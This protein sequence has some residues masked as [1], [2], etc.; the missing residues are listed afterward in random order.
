[1]ARIR[2]GF[3]VIP[4]GIAA[5]GIAAVA[6]RYLREIRAARQELER[7][8]SR[9][10]QTEFGPIEY[11]CVGSGYPVL[12][13]HGAMGGFDQG[14]MTA[15]WMAEHGFQVI[16]VSRFGYLRTPMPENANGDMQADANAC[17]LDALGI[18]K[19]AVFGA[20][21]G[22]PSAVRFAARYPGR[23]TALVLLSPA[24]P[25]EVT[26]APPK[27]ALALARNDF[28]Y[29]SM[30]TYL[31]PLMQ[32]AIGVPQGFKPTAEDAAEITRVLAKTLPSSGRGDL[33]YF[34]DPWA[35]EFHEQISESSPYPLGKIETPILVLNAQDDPFSIPAN[36]RRY[37]ERF[38]NARLHVVPDGGHFL[39]GHGAEVHAAITQFLNGVA[40][41]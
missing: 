29:W 33:Y 11:A 31:R 36:V 24:A 30:V 13:L 21:G 25:G 6:A 8:G 37:T 3:G 10:L 38:P 28:I 19:A 16:A 27:A 14:L 7:L 22:A 12:V 39:L 26:V 17:L 4:L 1:V 41:G 20:S 40:A 18:Q 32:R 23:T 5:G 34:A 15:G 2:I 9:M 35:F